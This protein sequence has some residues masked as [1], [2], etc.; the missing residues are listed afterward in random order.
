MIKEGDILKTL[1]TL[2]I[3]CSIRAYVYTVTAVQLLQNNSYMY[4]RNIYP[5]LYP[6][7]AQAHGTTV[8]SVKRSMERVV[9]LISENNTN[10]FSEI[11]GT[12]PPTP[13]EFL[14]KLTAYLKNN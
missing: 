12:Q 8:A 10:L 4:V 14:F 6:E 13:V 7:I 1:D 5:K 11:W 3:P 9:E 2:G